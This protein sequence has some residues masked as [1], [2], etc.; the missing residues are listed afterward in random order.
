MPDHGTSPD[1]SGMPV[2][3]P[4]RK[5]SLNGD[6]Y[7]RRPE[8]VAKLSEL[9]LISRSDLVE[10]SLIT[11]RADPQYVPSECLL[12]FLRASREDAASPQYEKFYRI[13][14]ERILRSLPREETAAGT[15]SLRKAD[16][17]EKVFD[18][19]HAL[20]AKDRIEYVEKLDFFEVRFDK[21][22]QG[23]RLDA[24]EQVRRA[25]DRSAAIDDDASGD[26]L[27]DVER[28]AGSFALF[29]KSEIAKLDYRS[30]LDAAIESLPLLQQRILELWKNDIPFDSIDPDARTIAK[31]LNKSDRTVR[32]HFQKACESL[33]K[34]LTREEHL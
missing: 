34:V 6:L 32:T 5:R 17:R 18:R 15:L 4:L 29:S 26:P 31:I 3:T 25:E 20:L 16:L 33:R 2:I 11:E 14:A 19:F 24:L 7:T 13:L 12:Y 9:L 23:F 22:L 27:V 28:A 1:C 10:R 8:T 30:A 21:M